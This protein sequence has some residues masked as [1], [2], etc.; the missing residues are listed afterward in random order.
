MPDGKQATTAVRG[1]CRAMTLERS[2]SPWSGPIVFCRRGPDAALNEVMFA[3]LG[4]R[5]AAW[6]EACA[7]GHGLG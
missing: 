5:R 3:L 7:C 6:K 2:L 1:L 4:G